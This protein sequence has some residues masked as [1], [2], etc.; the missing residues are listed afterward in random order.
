MDPRAAKRRRRGRE[1]AAQMLA[2]WDQNPAPGEQVIRDVGALTRASAAHLELA[3][4]L[5]RAAWKRLDE[6]DGRIAAAARPW[7]RDNMGRVERSVLRVGVAELLLGTAPPRVVLTE[8][9]EVARRYAGEGS[10]AFIH[11]V[12][13]AVIEGLGSPPG[14]P[15]AGGDAPR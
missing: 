3:G 9:V 8:S 12:V 4:T 2:S 5:A 7:W 13:H 10:T 15:R 14:A 6:I 11:A 1:L